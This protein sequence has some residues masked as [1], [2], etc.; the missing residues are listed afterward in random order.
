M[1][2]SKSSAFFEASN[3]FFLVFFISVLKKKESCDIMLRQYRTILIAQMRR[4]MFRQITQI[5][6]GN[7][8]SASNEICA[9]WQ[10]KMRAAR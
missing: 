7:R 5:E 10:K 4:R 3:K 9:V 1:V 8:G 6:A 2:F